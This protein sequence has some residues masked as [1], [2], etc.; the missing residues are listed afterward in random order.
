MSMKLIA[1]GNRL[2]GDD[3]L[4]ISIAESLYQW[5][6][7]KGIEVIIG[8][9]DFEYCLDKVEEG[10]HIIILDATW[11]GIEPGTVTENSLKDIYNLNSSQSTFS[12]HGYSLIRALKSC[13]PYIDGIVIGVEGYIFDFDLN[14]SCVITNRL[15][16]I[17]NKIKII[18]TEYLS[19]NIERK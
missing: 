19:I 6:Q 10:S 18:V 15:E 16:D 13:Y 7:D 5:L 17:R 4:A 8:E 11:F 14:L 3:G 2:M 1:I 9:T 12:Q